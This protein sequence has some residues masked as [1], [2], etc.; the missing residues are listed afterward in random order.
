MHSTMSLPFSEESSLG[1]IDHCDA[2]TS[3]SSTSSAA[4]ALLTL[5]AS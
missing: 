2:E 4:A 5:S 3:L 1:N